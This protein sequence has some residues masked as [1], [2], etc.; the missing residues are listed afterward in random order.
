MKTAYRS[1]ATL[2]L[3][4][5]LPVAATAQEFRTSYFMQTSN[6]RH[7]MNPAL[8]DTPY[9]SAL[10]G[11]I[12]VGTTS[13]IGV[14]SFIYKL[15]GNPRYDLTTFMSPTVSAS[16]FL[17]GLSNKNRLD[18]YVN[19]NLF[20]IGF[21]AFKGINLLEVN[22]RSNTNVSLPYELFEFMKTTGSRENYSLSDIGLR[23]QSY[24]EL[25]LGHSHRIN[26]QLT[27]GAKMKLL[28]GLAYADLSVERL[29]LTMN[30]D[31]WRV[32]GDA[33]LKAAVL[34]SA[35]SHEE[36]NKN[37]PDGR[38][39]VDGLDD[40]AFGM[41]GFGLAFDL[42]ATY[43]VTEDLTV[44]A[45]L[46]DLGFINW[47][48]TQQAS[49]RGEYT[50]GGFDN[51]YAGGNNTGNNKLG[52]QFED[53]GDDLE[54]LFAVYDDGEAS[55]SQTLAA[56]LN[57]GAEY[58]L[59]AYRPLRFGFLYTG[60]FHGLYSYHQAMLSAIVRPVKCLEATLNTAV[61]GTGCT[62][63][64]ALSLKLPH[65]DFYIGS[66]RFFGKLSK[67]VYLPL[68]KANSNLT[69]GMTFPL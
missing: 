46:T 57:I 44:S 21:R 54:E 1:L 38:Q 43:K 12:N 4:L 24:M 3:A 19:Y 40:V 39:R 68:N 11:G 37:A 27:I 66:D 31:E 25:A 61:G 6:L 7:Q 36:P 5:L 48:K 16:K 41:P 29:D 52:D 28:F 15:D 67:S 23:T 30:G 8:L 22:L 33:R 55:A 53:L 56:T 63:G 64:G 58:T 26:D 20:S 69:F 32:V 59:P 60:R 9:F 17:D 10:F 18:A 45:G 62:F 2:L 65:F 14:K 51:I 49:S 34:N 42:G 35:F 50:F 47:G 13:N